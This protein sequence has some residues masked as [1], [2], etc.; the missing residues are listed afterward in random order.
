MN[1]PKPRSHEINTE[2]DNFQAEIDT[3]LNRGVTPENVDTYADDA[4][5]NLVDIIGEIVKSQQYTFP[6]KRLIISLMSRKRFMRWTALSAITS[7]MA[8]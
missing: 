1:E 7:I 6:F 3:I 5:E 4:L 2:K 8:A